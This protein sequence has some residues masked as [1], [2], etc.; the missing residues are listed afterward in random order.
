MVST[1][2]PKVLPSLHDVTFRFLA[3]VPL[4]AAA[5][6]ATLAPRVEI[7]T[8]IVC[9][10]YKPEYTIGRGNDTFIS[11]LSSGIFTSIGKQLEIS[12]VA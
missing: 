12:Y 10:V 7:L 8:R 11:A 5:G 9:E 4:V 3:S 1:M 2:H 6:A